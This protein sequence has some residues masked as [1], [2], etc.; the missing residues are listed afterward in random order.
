MRLVLLAA[1]LL[2][3]QQLGQDLGSLDAP[4]KVK[5]Y[6]EFAAEQQ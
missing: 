3:A 5:Q 2:L 4:K 1:G 6:V